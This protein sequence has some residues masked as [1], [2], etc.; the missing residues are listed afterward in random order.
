VTVESTVKSKVKTT[1]RPSNHVMLL[2]SSASKAQ[3]KVKALAAY[4]QIAVNISFNC[5]VTFPLSFNRVLDALKIIN[6]DLIPALGLQCR[7]NGF[8]YVYKMVGAC[9]FPLI[10]SG[11]FL[12]AYLFVFTKE[13]Y[14]RHLHF[15]KNEAAI[16][17]YEVPPRMKRV[18]TKRQIWNLKLVFAEID[19]DGSGDFERD[20]L[21]EV[22]AKVAFLFSITAIVH[23]VIP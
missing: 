12:L 2:L 9:F 8:D 3:V 4:F 22:Q 5:G 14:R 13:T 10:L 20:E 21:I 6:V 11:G 19:D 7:Y 18:F 23:G 1:L 15:K 16:K 17:S